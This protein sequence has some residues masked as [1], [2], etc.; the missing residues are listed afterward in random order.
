MAARRRQLEGSNGW[1]FCRWLLPPRPHLVTT[2]LAAYKGI[3]L[4][5]DAACRL[6]QGRVQPRRHRGDPGTNRPLTRHVRGEAAV[7]RVHLAL[8]EI[9]HANGVAGQLVARGAGPCVARSALAVPVLRAGRCRSRGRAG[10]ESSGGAVGAE[11]L[12]GM[13]RFGCDPHR[14]RQARAGEAALS[15][16]SLPRGSW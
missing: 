10:G 7:H 3:P 14:P 1:A 2:L 16:C 12:G 8:W 15:G 5:A 11:Y 6:E 4:S 9:G 13:R